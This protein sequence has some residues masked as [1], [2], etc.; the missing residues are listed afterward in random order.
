[1]SAVQQTVDLTNCDREPIHIPGSIQPHG[2]MLVYDAA[3]S[4]VLRHSENA[5]TLL[6][7]SGEI[8]GT[9]AEVHLGAELVHTLRNAV[10]GVGE[11]VRPALLL[12]QKL[13]DRR[14]DIAVH[15]YRSNTIVE[16]EVA[17]ADNNAPLH[18]AR[19]MI[20]RISQLDS[21]EK[22]VQQSA[23]LIRGTLGYDRVMVYRF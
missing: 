15:R 22:L 10:S 4:T 17:G 20:G 23:R 7:L 12:G 1:M 6:G 9:P 2:A 16:F 18:L 5:G 13:G 21:V 11:G 8:N 3:L 14:F 19:S